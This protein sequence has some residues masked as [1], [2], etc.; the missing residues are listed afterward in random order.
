MPWPTRVPC[1]KGSIE[2]SPVAVFQRINLLISLLYLPTIVPALLIVAPK[3]RR[4]W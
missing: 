2:A 1:K 3:K 4:G